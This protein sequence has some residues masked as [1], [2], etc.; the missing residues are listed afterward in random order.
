MG[1]NP[2]RCIDADYKLMDGEA[3]FASI[4]IRYGFNRVMARIEIVGVGEFFGSF[5][6]V[7]DGHYDWETHAVK[8]AL[9]KLRQRTDVPDKFKYAMLRYGSR[10]F[11]SAFWD[12]GYPIFDLSWRKTADKIDSI[13]A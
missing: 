2:Y 8:R 7:L 5:E 13:S 10:G 9:R 4:S 3:H 1:N 12:V 6:G 11:Y